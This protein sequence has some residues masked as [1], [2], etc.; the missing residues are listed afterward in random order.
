[1]SGSPLRKWLRLPLP[2]VLSAIMAI[3]AAVIAGSVWLSTVR[4]SVEAN[5]LAIEEIREDVE[6]L[7]DL[8]HQVRRIEDAQVRLEKTTEDIAVRQEQLRDA[9]HSLDNAIVEV[10][11]LAL[12]SP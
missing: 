7:E 3:V 8:P 10:K 5:G 2:W 11:A 9:Q 6:A 1:M 4:A 12:R